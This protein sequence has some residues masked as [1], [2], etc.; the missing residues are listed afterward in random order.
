MAKPKLALIPA[1]I[2]T[3]VYSVLPSDGDGDFAF[4]RATKA[5][6]I[7]SLGLIEEVDSGKNRLNYD[8]LDGK[9]YGCPHLLLEP[10][11]TNLVKYSESFSQSYWVKE[12]TSITSNVVISPDGTLNAKK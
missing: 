5:T 2:G 12:K 1:T 10:A 11:R 6:R 3:K 8:L 7:N 9:V 4:T